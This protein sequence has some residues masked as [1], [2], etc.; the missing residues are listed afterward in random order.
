[1]SGWAAVLILWGA[2]VALL[3][4]ALAAAALIDL[5]EGKREP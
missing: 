2:S 3:L 4:L 1:V 5:A